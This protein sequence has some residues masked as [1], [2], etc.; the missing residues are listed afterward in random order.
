METEERFKN[1]EKNIKYL[2]WTVVILLLGGGVLFLM[3]LGVRKYFIHSATPSTPPEVRAEQFT[4]VGPNG[5][6]RAIF[7]SNEGTGYLQT[8]DPN[9]NKLV[10]IGK[11]EWGDGTLST[12]G[13]EGNGLVSIG[14]TTTGGSIITY[15]SEGNKLNELSSGIFGGVITTFETLFG[16]RTVVIGDGEVNIYGITTDS[17]LATLSYIHESG[18]LITYD[19]EGKKTTYIGNDPSGSGVGVVV[20]LDKSS[21]IATFAGSVNGQGH[22]MVQNEGVP[23]VIIG[24][25]EESGPGYVETYDGAGKKLVTI[26][27]TVDGEGAIATFNRGGQVKNQWP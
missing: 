9:G 16:S 6:T 27:A 26:G 15:N 14:S 11:T 1:L 8:F 2:S 19:K 4:V 20:T 24:S 17:P 12:F 18:V 22:F 21:N 7:G 10:E 13:I 25:N 5:E 3:L 23:A